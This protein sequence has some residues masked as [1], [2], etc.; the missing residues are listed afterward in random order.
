[1]LVQID[2]KE[3]VEDSEAEE[4]EFFTDEGED[5]PEDGESLGEDDSEDQEEDVA[6]S[7]DDHFV[8]PDRYEENPPTKTTKKASN[9]KVSAAVVDLTEDDPEIDLTK[10]MPA[11]K[12]MKISV[13]RPKPAP[14]PPVIAPHPAIISNPL[15][16]IFLQLE[17]QYQWSKKTSWISKVNFF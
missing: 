9:P 12:A 11:F 3:I 10:P 15:H 17:K 16:K 5:E 6:D 13:P 1:M 14:A 2:W 7:S 4:D 8:V